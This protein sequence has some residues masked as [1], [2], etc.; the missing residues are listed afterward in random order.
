MLRALLLLLAA[1][2]IACGGGGGGTIEH[3]EDGGTYVVDFSGMKA[4]F[5]FSRT[6]DQIT[7]T[8]GKTRNATAALA[9][10][11]ADVQYQYNN[12]ASVFPATITFSE[13][14]LTLAGAI[15]AHGTTLAFTGARGLAGT[16]DLDALGPP[17]FVT[18]SYIDMAKIGAI[19]R[20]R[21]GCGHDYSDDLEDLRN[22]KHY[23]RPSGPGDV[24]V[25]SPVN[26]TILSCSTADDGGGI[27]IV[28]QPDGFPEFSVTLFHVVFPAGNLTPG[29]HL[30][31]GEALGVNA[32]YPEYSD[33]SVSVLTPTGARY[34]SFFDVMDGALFDTT[35]RPLGLA[36]PSDLIIG[37]AE[38]DAHPLTLDPSLPGGYFSG[39]DVDDVQLLRFPS[40]GDLA[41]ER[42]S[43]NTVRLTWTDRTSDE[44]EF[45]LTYSA[46]ED[47]PSLATVSVAANATAFDW[48]GLTGGA[49][50]YLRVRARRGDDGTSA[51]SNAAFVPATAPTHFVV[52][53]TYGSDIG[54][55]TTAPIPAGRNAK[56]Y[57]LTKEAMAAFDSGSPMAVDFSFSGTTTANGTDLSYA[58]PTSVDG[59]QRYVVSFLIL[60]PTDLAYVGFDAAGKTK[61]QLAGI[62]SGKLAMGD[63]GPVADGARLETLS[64]A[65]GRFDLQFVDLPGLGP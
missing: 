44:T 37:K 57:F 19:T 65:G 13:D 10:R 18:A 20:F 49:P 53:S 3:P 40:P 36:A 7:Y 26:G 64:A 32:D 33:V 1:M 30:D 31:A 46:T 56:V 62:P 12:A 6:G 54:M 35:F 47:G 24:Q 34:L 16:Y 41:A 60:D 4:L 23:F 22:M 29:Q 39:Q 45:E 8:F 42:L 11:K 38:R 28:I 51:F 21:S 15:T 55:T 52:P 17:T 5:R 27:E 50:Y 25:F 48:A 2:A 61:A 59:Q 9:G 14:F 43:G 63:T 58:I